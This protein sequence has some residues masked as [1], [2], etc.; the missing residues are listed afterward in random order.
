MSWRRK[1][2]DD[3]KRWKEMFP[4]LPF[5]LFEESG[6]FN[7]DFME[8]MMREI[9]RMMQHIDTSDPE[10]IRKKL[11]PMVWGWNM[12][13]GPDGKPVFKEFGNVKPSVKGAP[14]AS[15]D[16]EP[17]VDVFIE[18]KVVRVIA[19]L[20]GVDKHDINVKTTESKIII[21]AVSG[22]RNYSTER[23]LS[24]RIKPKTANAK[25]KNGILELTVDRKEPVEAESG[26]EVKIE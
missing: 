4:W 11:G 14:V 19:E 23:D 24:V 8:Q 15:K 20:P 10:A 2:D 6:M 13:V 17:L 1:K 22:D 18:D 7:E 21:E 9:E 12:Q 26:F 3:F 16:R 25:Y 5:D